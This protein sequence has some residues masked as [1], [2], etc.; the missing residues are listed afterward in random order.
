MNGRIVG[1]YQRTSLTHDIQGVIRFTLR[2]CPTKF[3]YA[4]IK[5]IE[6]INTKDR[7]ILLKIYLPYLF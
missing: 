3:N 1:Q 7:K 4:L 6:L 2:I 5:S